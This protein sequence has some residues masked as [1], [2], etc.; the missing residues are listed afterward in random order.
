ME[1]NDEEE[2]EK[3]VEENIQKIIEK[4]EKK[5]KKNPK[6]E[7]MINLRKKETKEI[8]ESLI[9]FHLLKKIILHKKK[10]EKIE[11]IENFFFSE[12]LKENYRKFFSVILNGINSLHKFPILV[13]LFFD[14]LNDFFCLK[15]FFAQQ[16]KIEKKSK[17]FSSK[18]VSLVNLNLLVSLKFDSR[19]LND[20]FIDN[21]TSQENSG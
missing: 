9:K 18:I 20:F 16:K 21:P 3:L 17:K 12:F 14:G 6:R 13:E 10:I 5:E 4:I 11:K 8:V 2:E 15:F 7:E 19:F 1:I